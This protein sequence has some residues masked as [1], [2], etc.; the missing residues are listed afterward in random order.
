[1]LFLT[2]AKLSRPNIRLPLCV[3]SVTLIT[4]AVTR[5]VLK[6]C[7]RRHDCCMNQSPIHQ[8]RFIAPPRAE[9]YS[10]K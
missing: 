10:F 8:E 3:R 1:M 7:L 9:F 6:V 4:V 2:E 5:T